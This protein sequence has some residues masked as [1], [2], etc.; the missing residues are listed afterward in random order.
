MASDSGDNAFMEPVTTLIKDVQ[1][2]ASEDRVSRIQN[3]VTHVAN[4]EQEAK[5]QAEEVKDLT[6]IYKEQQ[7]N[8]ERAVEEIKKEYEAHRQQ[9]LE[10]FREDSVKVSSEKISLEAEVSRLQG[11]VAEAEKTIEDLSKREID[12]KNKNEDHVKRQ[13]NYLERSIEQQ[14]RIEQLEI[15]L[16]QQTSEI[17]KFKDKIK[18]QQFDVSAANASRDRAKIEATSA[19]GRTL[20]AEERCKQIRGFAQNL[21][22]DKREEM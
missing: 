22:D 5:R 18:Q 1:L 10:G 11:S 19:G 14:K 20:R 21:L 15:Q 9:L 3:L 8:H 16:T 17:D 12:L 6:A 2:L 13:K 4:L 7:V